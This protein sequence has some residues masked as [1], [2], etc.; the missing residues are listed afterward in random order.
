MLMDKRGYF[1]LWLYVL[2]LLLFSLYLSLSI[3]EYFTTVGGIV[4]T[5]DNKSGQC[6]ECMTFY[7]DALAL[8]DAVQII[9][10]IN[11]Q[12]IFIQSIFDALDTFLQNRKTLCVSEDKAPLTVD[13]YLSCLTDYINNVSCPLNISKAGC[14]IKNTILSTLTSK[15][16][17]CGTKTVFVKGN[18]I[19]PAICK[20]VE[21]LEKNIL[22]NLINLKTDFAICK[23]NFAT[24]D[25]LCVS[26]FASNISNRLQKENIEAAKTANDKNILIS[27][28]DLNKTMFDINTM[29]A[30]QNY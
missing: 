27:K 20:T 7:S 19:E 16:I 18:A 11:S 29:I 4:I 17:N 9:P 3:K 14:K 6:F 1:L 25:T 30:T 10:Y 22:N 8:Q 24:T 2:I 28:A 23:D 5:T 15:S 26:Q 12:N 13:K 21:E